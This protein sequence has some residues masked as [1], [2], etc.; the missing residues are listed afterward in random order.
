[1]SVNART[2][3][4]F[5][6]E[7][8]R[9]LFPLGVIFGC[10]GVGHWLAYAA[11]WRDSYSG[12]YHAWLQVGAYMTCFIAGFL[13][14]ALPRIASA[15]PVSGW[16]LGLVLALLCAQF[17][18][19]Q[20]GAW[21]AA[22]GCFAGLLVFLSY[23]AGRRFAR[24]RVAAPLPAEF[25]VWIPAGLFLGL[26]GTAILILGQAG[27]A[28]AWWLGVGRPMVSQGFLLGIVLGVGGFMAARLMGR[29]P[30]PEG[31]T[32]F[33]LLA[34]ALFFASFWAEGVGAVGPA[35]L[36]RAGA[37]TAVFSRTAQFYRPPAAPH[38]YARLLRLSIWMLVLGL[39]G[40]GFVPARR[41]AMLHLVFLGGL[42]L[43]TFSIGTMVCL[44]HAG[45][46]HRLHRPL[47]ILRVVG[48][49]VA[50]SLAARLI[51]EFYPAAFF[52]WLGVA[53]VCWLVAGL[54]WLVFVF[55]YVARP[56]NEGAVEQIHG[57]AARGRLSEEEEV[58]GLFSKM[59][60][61]GAPRCVR[62]Q[63]G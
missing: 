62:G 42:S 8:Y 7:P 9:I 13:M 20:A 55:P 39:W 37:A 5:R 35:Y 23:F 33:H 46:V 49:G 63:A 4:A 25:S 15:A 17:A 27:V 2:L 24:R 47:W 38:A 19:L 26:L 41:T 11:G 34:G 10:L 14:T 44:S 40:A 43:M 56:L 36:A 3:D 59:E 58:R 51:A 1:M 16:E 29:K 6:R 45:E 48:L 31:Q 61:L 21:V 50:G 53:A 52:L 57:R 54:S 32:P 60:R 28:P 18:A 30:V 22:E 12:F